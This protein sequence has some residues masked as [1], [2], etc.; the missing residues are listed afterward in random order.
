MITSACSKGLQSPI[1][2]RISQE[3]DQLIFLKL[4]N[5]GEMKNEESNL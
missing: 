5:K 4:K 3:L 1:V 2:I